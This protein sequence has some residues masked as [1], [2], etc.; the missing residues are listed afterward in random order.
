MSGTRGDSPIEYWSEDE[1]SDPDPFDLA[2]INLALAAFG[3]TAGD[4]AVSQL[5][6]RQDELNTRATLPAQ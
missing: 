3:R 6:E 1:P 5:A 2:D 4:D